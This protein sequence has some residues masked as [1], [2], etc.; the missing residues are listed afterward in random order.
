[1]TAPVP[2]LNLNKEQVELKKK[3]DE[4]GNKILTEIPTVKITEIS[5]EELKTP[6]P[7]NELEE[8]KVNSDEEVQE[9]LSPSEK[10]WNEEINVK[11][12]QNFNYEMI[13]LIGNYLNLNENTI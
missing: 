1:M 11:A 3:F 4:N 2:E 10:F 8:M 5:S 12:H 13:V 7:T 6:L 9:E